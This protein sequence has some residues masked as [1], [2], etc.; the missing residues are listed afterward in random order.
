MKNKYDVIVI[1]GGS[2]GFSI[3]EQISHQGL[4]IEAGEKI[5]E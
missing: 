4:K 3:L 2:A 5:Y 1:G